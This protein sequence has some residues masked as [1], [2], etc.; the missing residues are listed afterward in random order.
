MS[1]EKSVDNAMGAGG[2]STKRHNAGV[3]RVHAMS[4]PWKD[5]KQRDS[6]EMVTREQK[7]RKSARAK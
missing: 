4:R 6:R 3:A 7:T 2:M 5:P 1:N